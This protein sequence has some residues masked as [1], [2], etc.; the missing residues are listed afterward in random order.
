L[1]QFVARSSSKERLSL[2]FLQR[3]LDL[4][5]KCRAAEFGFTTQE[6]CEL[7][8]EV[9]NRSLAEGCSAHERVRFVATLRLD[10]LVLARACARGNEHAW[11]RF[12]I[13]YR[14]KL[15]GAAAA[16]AQE[17]S[18]AREL[19]DSLY[20]DLY[21]TRVRNDGRRISKLESYLG[22]GSLEGWLRTVIA[23][24]HVNRFRYQQKLVG[25]DEAIVT[26]TNKTL[27]GTHERHG[28]QLAQAT[29]SALAALS[30]EERFL[31]AAYYLDGRTLAEIGCMLH[32]HESTV[33]RRLEK[34]I[35]TL[36]KRV[37][38]RLRAMGISKRAA[39]EIFHM[40]VRDLNVDVR[41][42][43]AQERQA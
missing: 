7:L 20:A 12:L 32:V 35:A 21:G 40:D 34:V 36:R 37:L 5:Q 26:G 6:F 42:R 2:Y 39:E 23:Q 24:E 38:E 30:S 18:A 28:A 11:E 19:A 14:E 8:E 27:E 25:F 22:R 3:I 43:L 15:Y 13:L 10:D 33:S 29:D 31:L 1:Q 41:N 4:Y 9:A 17:A 16:I